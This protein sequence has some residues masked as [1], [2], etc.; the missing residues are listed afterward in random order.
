MNRGTCGLEVTAF[1]IRRRA[2]RSFWLAIVDVHGLTEAGT[3]LRWSLF[4]YHRWVD[5][6]HCQPA[7]EFRRLGVCGHF[8]NIGGGK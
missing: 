1:E 2:P 3:V 8:W 6:I 4:V 5:D 7:R